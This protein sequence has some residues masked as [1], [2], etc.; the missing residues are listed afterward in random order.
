M[1]FSGMIVNAQIAMP[2][3][4]CSYA[5]KHY[6]VDAN[7]IPGSVYT[8]K[9]DGV[10]QTSS[11]T[12][13]IDITW[14][15]AG[16]Y[17]LEVQEQT[18]AGCLGQLM[19]GMVFVIN[20]PIVVANCNS[21]V[22]EGTSINLTV[23]NV[24]SGTYKWTGP[25]G[26]SSTLQNS[27]IDIA[28]WGDGGIYSLS[29]FANGCISEPVNFSVIVNDCKVDL[30]IPEGFSPNAD[31]INDEFVIRGIDNYPKNGI[32]IFN[33][34]GNKVFEA[35]PYQNNWDGKAN[36]GVKVGGDELPVGTYFYLLDLG[37]GSKVYKGD[38]YLNR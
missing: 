18:A 11:I 36:R 13:E 23:E 2:D 4:V 27:I 28:S 26:Y 22:C 19:S 37:D 38:I 16:I 17:M 15:T 33:R 3:S 6:Y 5:V 14:N 8:W 7:P 29:V 30:F 34:W 24:A 31:G 20:A 21:P 35:S 1:L 25:N 12:N 32:V 10:T 9:I